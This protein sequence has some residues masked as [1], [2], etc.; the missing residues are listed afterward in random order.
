MSL[1]TAVMGEAS[2]NLEI[3][4]TYGSKD[5]NINIECDYL[6]YLSFSVE[7]KTMEYTKY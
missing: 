2:R 4:I 3:Y 5:L 7:N 1:E 6:N